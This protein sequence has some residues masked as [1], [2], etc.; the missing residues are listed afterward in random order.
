MPVAVPVAVIV[1]A[2]GDYFEV[3][4]GSQSCQVGSTFVRFLVSLL[5]FCGPANGRDLPGKA[6]I[7]ASHNVART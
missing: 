5:T 6:A 2:S 3:H 7:G 1:P 4:V